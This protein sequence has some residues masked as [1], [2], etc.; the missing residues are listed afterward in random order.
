MSICTFTGEAGLGALQW[1]ICAASQ[2]GV[3]AGGTP[4]PQLLGLK[5]RGRGSLLKDSSQVLLNYRTIWCQGAVC[6]QPHRDAY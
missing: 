3:G 2:I 5:K 4:E 1:D 6:M